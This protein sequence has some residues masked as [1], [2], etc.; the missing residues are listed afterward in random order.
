MDT[1]VKIVKDKKWGRV[2]RIKTG[3]GGSTSYLAYGKWGEYIGSYC[4]RRAAVERCK[5]VEAHVE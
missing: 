5:A 4:T 3:R 1:K 2:L